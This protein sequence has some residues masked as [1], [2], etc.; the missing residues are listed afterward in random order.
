[1]GPLRGVA[2]GSG[3]SMKIRRGFTGV[4]RSFMEVICG[5]LTVVPKSFKEFFVGWR[6]SKVQFGLEW[7]CG[8]LGVFMCYGEALDDFL[9][10]VL[11]FSLNKYNILKFS[12]SSSS[13]FVCLELVENRCITIQIL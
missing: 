4:L 7:F 2:G 1:M 8:I 6:A 5:F 3:V 9:S 10:L 11:Y 12:V 13:N